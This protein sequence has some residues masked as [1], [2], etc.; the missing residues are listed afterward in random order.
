M[1]V[2]KTGSEPKIIKRTEL[3]QKQLYTVTKFIRALPADAIKFVPDYRA[4]AV[5]ASVASCDPDIAKNTVLSFTYEAGRKYQIE[6]PKGDFFINYVKGQKK[7]D[8]SSKFGDG[9]EF[10]IF[11]PRGNEKYQVLS[12]SSKI[13]PNLPVT[14]MGLSP[15]SPWFIETRTYSKNETGGDSIETRKDF[16]I[17]YLGKNNFKVV[18]VSPAVLTLRIIQVDFLVSAEEQKTI[19]EEN[20]RMLVNLLKDFDQRKKFLPDKYRF[21]H[22]TLTPSGKITGF[23]G[24]EG[25]DGFRQAY[26]SKKGQIS[27]PLIT[28]RFAVNEM[29]GKKFGKK[30]NFEQIKLSEDDKLVGDGLS[31]GCVNMI[32]SILSD[33]ATKVNATLANVS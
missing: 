21:V 31:E 10:V 9:T 8:G 29:N 13:D 7:D 23:F 14:Y 5:G 32:R 30:S 6:T 15:N 3:F 33:S 24:H 22:A 12:V 4:W 19:K 20:A 16:G 25:R 18:S 28:A 26:R 17:I 1:E 11:D 2:K 27:E